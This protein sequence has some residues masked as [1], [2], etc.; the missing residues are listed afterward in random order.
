MEILFDLVKLLSVVIFAKYS[1]IIRV[2]S[3][4]FSYFENSPKK[5]FIGRKLSAIVVAH[6]IFLE[7]ILLL[8][9]L[10]LV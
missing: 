2:M 5:Y 10:V 4:Y 7:E 8:A 1:L 3:L 9:M 6:E